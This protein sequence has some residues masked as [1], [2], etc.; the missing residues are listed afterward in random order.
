MF[1]NIVHPSQKNDFGQRLNVAESG[2]E[3][4]SIILPKKF[5]GRSLRDLIY[6]ADGAIS[7]SH[8]NPFHN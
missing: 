4:K 7:S 6:Y 2:Q 1:V 8:C 3:A 5:P